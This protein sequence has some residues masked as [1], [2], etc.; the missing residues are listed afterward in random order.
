MGS[1]TGLYG[2]ASQNIVTLVFTALRT[3]NPSGSQIFTVEFLPR[4][5]CHLI[6]TRVAV[7]KA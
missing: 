5:L 6:Q 1:T 2:I 7:P 3:S 4:H